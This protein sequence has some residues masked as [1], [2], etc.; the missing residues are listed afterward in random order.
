VGAK[1][2]VTLQL[3]AP[4]T[5]VN[6]EL[7]EGEPERPGPVNRKSIR[8]IGELKRPQSPCYKCGNEEFTTENEDSVV[9][10]FVCTKCESP[11]T[12]IQQKEEYSHA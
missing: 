7:L 6:A 11:K 3:V 2:R 5:P 10:I 12:I 4:V 8:R 9:V 1:R